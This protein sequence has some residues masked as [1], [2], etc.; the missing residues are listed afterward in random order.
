[1]SQ[2]QSYYTHNEEYAEFLAN[3]DANFYAKYA[4]ALKPDSASG[5]ALDVGCGAGQGYLWSPAVLLND[6]P[7]L[8]GRLARS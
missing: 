1:M 3:W 4:D 7:A 8:L 2:Q 6:V 5:K